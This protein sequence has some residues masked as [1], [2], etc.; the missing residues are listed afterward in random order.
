MITARP[1]SP[2][3]GLLGALFCSL[4]IAVEFALGFHVRGL[5]L[6]LILSLSWLLVVAFALFN[7]R[8]RGLSVLLSVPVAAYIL[9]SSSLQ[10][11]V[12]CSLNSQSCP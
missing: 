8:A 10:L 5:L 9:T 1:I 7:Y 4:A 2:A 3:V 12:A 11:A 6:N